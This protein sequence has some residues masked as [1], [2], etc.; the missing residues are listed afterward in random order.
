MGQAVISGTM[1][2]YKRIDDH[3]L[4]STSSRNGVVT[5]NSTVAL[6]ADGKVMTVT[7]TRVGPNAGKEPSVSVYDKQ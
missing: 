3:T 5:G 7:T 4:A 2:A 6:S 1:I